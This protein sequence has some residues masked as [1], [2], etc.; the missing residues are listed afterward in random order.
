MG[1]YIFDMIFRKYA[2]KSVTYLNLKKFWSLEFVKIAFIDENYKSK[3]T[4]FD[5]YWEIKH[6]FE[7]KYLFHGTITCF[8][9]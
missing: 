4:N 1:L 2:S 3:L 6:R 5:Q 7:N 8:K 9:L